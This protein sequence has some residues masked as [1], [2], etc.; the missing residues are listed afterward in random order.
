[1]AKLADFGLAK[2]VDSNALLS[3]RSPMPSEYS[4]RTLNDISEYAAQSFSW[5][6]KFKRGK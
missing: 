4:S 6:Q 1:M 3:V 2:I 5:P